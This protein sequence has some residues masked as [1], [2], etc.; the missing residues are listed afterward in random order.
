MDRHLTYVGMTRHREAVTLY[1]A[2]DE[3]AG[4]EALSARLSR[5]QA[6]ETTLDYAQRRG[7][8]A[9][10][11][12]RSRAPEIARAPTPTKTRGM[13]DGLR[14]KPARPSPAMD[15][16]MRLPARER[17]PVLS[18]PAQGL[19][20]AVDR[21]AR[22]WEGA[23]RMRAQKLPVLQYQERELS[24]ASAVLDAA[25]PNATRDLHNAMRHE[26]VT[27]RAMN[28]LTG[29][30]RA[31]ELV[32]G[33]RHEERVAHDPN[34][35]AERMVKEWKSLEA[36]HERL[37]GWQHREARTQ[38]ETRLKSIAGT[39]KRDPQLE[40]LMRARAKDLGIDMTSRLGRV[41]QAPSM[42]Q[43]IGHIVRGRDR[44]MSL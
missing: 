40:S 17:A 22:A 21:Y 32:A 31:A 44:G 9:P 4:M 7:I 20:Q 43:A 37:D 16:D 12:T 36:R 11:A 41:M 15:R 8:E 39:L 34:L 26:P 35:R 14:L 29:K 3:F 23:E 33:I 25:R 1:A 42:E 24:E 13:F 19:E 2:R 5:S 28:E 10:S 27:R 38:I 30:E 6:K 18:Q